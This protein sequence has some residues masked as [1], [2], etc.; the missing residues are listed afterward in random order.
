HRI[1]IIDTPGHI[2]FTAEVQRSLRVLDGAVVV[3]DGVAGVEPQSETV[4]HQA[5]KFKVPRICFINKMD[6]VGASFEK[7]LESIWQKLSPNAL[8]LQ[9]PIGEEDKFEG[10]IDLLAMKALKF[11]GDWGQVVK[12]EEIPQDLV[13]RAREWREKLVEKISAEDEELL[14]KY[15]AKKEITI[16]ELRK[17]LRKATLDYK[18]I[19]VF[20][21]SA[22]KNK[23]IQPLLDGIIYYLPSPNDLLPVKGTCPKTGKDLERKSDDS[24]P[25]AALAFK[26]AT[27][28]YVGTLTY[29]RVYSGS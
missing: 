9:L 17:A 11:E 29:F 7:S 20:C 6:R 5:D 22:L 23:G 13:E 4:W 12:E 18:L 2:D 25:F 3:F 24:E 21:G 27:D 16:E 10:V 1:N 14:E 28:P 19:P 15:L 26:I 8:A